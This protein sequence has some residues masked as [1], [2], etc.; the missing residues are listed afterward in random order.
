MV[1]I[2]RTCYQETFK[3]SNNTECRY[4]NETLV[5]IDIVNSELSVNKLHID[6]VKED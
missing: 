2:V 1:R 5:N 4:N 3:V 6:Q